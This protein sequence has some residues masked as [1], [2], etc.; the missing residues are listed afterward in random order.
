MLCKSYTVTLPLSKR[1]GP[2]PEV[3]HSDEAVYKTICHLFSNNGWYDFNHLTAKYMLVLGWNRIWLPLLEGSCIALVWY[4][5][6][7]AVIRSCD[8][9]QV[10]KLLLIVWSFYWEENIYNGKSES[11]LIYFFNRIPYDILKFTRICGYALMLPCFVIKWS[12]T[13]ASA[14]VKSTRPIYLTP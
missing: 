4:S 7:K 2:C 11:H 9:D 8:Y 10:L 12:F 3:H 14:L 1:T 6:P 5:C 13:S